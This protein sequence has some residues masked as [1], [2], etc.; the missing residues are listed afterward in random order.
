[1]KTDRRRR[2]E[3]RHRAAA[4]AVVVAIAT[5]DEFRQLR[6]L[7]CEYCGGEI[8]LPAVSCPSLVFE[9][10]ASIN[11]ASHH[12]ENR[13]ANSKT[14]R[15][16]GRSR[17]AGRAGVRHQRSPRPGTGSALRFV[18]SQIGSKNGE[19]LAAEIAG[20]FPQL[21]EPWP[22]SRRSAFCASFAA[23]GL[24]RHAR[25]GPPSHPCLR[26]GS[27]ECDPCVHVR[28]EIGPRMLAAAR[29]KHCLTGDL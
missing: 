7:A 28:D 6:G 16:T 18:S 2:S 21:H 10:L 1:M 29:N 26:T 3:R 24:T 17:P 27:P 19:P 13:R 9:S 20:R 5:R 12:V 25:P 15:W 11:D 14:R 4:V 22:S 23:I 8:T